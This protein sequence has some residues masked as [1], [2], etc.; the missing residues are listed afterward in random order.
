MTTPSIQPATNPQFDGLRL[1]AARVLRHA[2]ESARFDDER[3]SEETV[4]VIA[5]GDLLALSRALANLS[6]RTA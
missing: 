3:Q 2:E 6:G 4:Y 5:A 1:A